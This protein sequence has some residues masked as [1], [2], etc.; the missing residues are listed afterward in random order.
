MI[1]L[2]LYHCPCGNKLL[3]GGIEMIKK[4]ALGTLTA[5]LLIIGATTVFAETEGSGAT[6]NKYL[7]LNTQAVQSTQTQGCYGPQCGVSPCGSV[8]NGY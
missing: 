3:K 5:A 4:L 8:N 2:F 6:E 1:I 7:Q